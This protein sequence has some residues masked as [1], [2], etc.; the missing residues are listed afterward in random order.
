MSIEAASVLAAVLVGAGATLL[1]DLWSLF[2]QRAF[3]VPFPNLCLLGRWLCHMPKGKF[4]HASIASAPPKRFECTVGWIAHY[5]IGAAFALV[6]VALAPAGWL[7]RPTL[8]P[9]M[10]FGFGTVLIP[11]LVMQ[12]A[13]GLGVAA[14]KTPNPTAARLKS[15]MSHGVFGLG[16]YASAVAASQV[17]SV[18]A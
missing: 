12:P 16:L 4:V 2:L 18:H 8:L 13:Y 5:A 17:L 9:A 3:K 7:A 6:F 11:Y 15:L 10:L 1:L 14:S